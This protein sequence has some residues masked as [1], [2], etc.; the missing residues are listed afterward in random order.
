[1]TRAFLGVSFWHDLT[2][3]P[4]LYVYRLGGSVAVLILSLLAARVLSGRVRTGLQRT[5]IGPNPT[6]LLGRI[7]RTAVYLIGFLSILAIFS[8]PFTALAA[9]VGVAAL[10]LSLSL[11]DLLKNLIAGIYLLAERPFHIGDEITVSGVTGTI[12]DIQLRVTLLHTEAGE[13]IVMPNQTVFTQVIVNNTVGGTRAAA[14]NLE[15]PRALDAQELT[16]QVL[17]IVSG[18]ITAEERK[19]ELRPVGVTPDTT[20]W[21]LSI[22]LSDGDELSHIMVMLGKAFPEITIEMA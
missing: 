19:P 22:W 6:V 7:T 8:V 12:D 10:A 17:E 14:L 5:S 2:Q 4:G 9:V 11:Q 13:R 18:I 21:R 1:M 16:R 3:D 15:F 20:K